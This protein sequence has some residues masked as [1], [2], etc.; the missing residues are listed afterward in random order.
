MTLSVMVT[1]ALLFICANK[2][3]ELFSLKF[4]QI[5]YVME[6]GGGRVGSGGGH[7]RVSL[8]PV[9]P[10]EETILANML[11]EKLLSSKWTSLHEVVIKTTDETI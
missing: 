2:R 7:R 6:C 3:Q 1:D 8:T 5:T 4:G 10:T 11:V 9:P